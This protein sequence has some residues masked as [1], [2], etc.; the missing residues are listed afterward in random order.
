MGNLSQNV[1][2]LNVDKPSRISTSSIQAGG[3]VVCCVD[4]LVGKAMVEGWG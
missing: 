2:E 3:A 1:P 4:A